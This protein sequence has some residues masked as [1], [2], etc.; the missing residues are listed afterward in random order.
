ML[1]AAFI[2]APL[3]PWSGRQQNLDRY[4]AYIVVAFVA[5]G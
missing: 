4:A 3:T 1:G 2:V 5:G